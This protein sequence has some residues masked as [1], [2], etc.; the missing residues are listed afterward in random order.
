[1]AL[2]SELIVEI[3]FGRVKV[4]PA[5]KRF[6]EMDI[7]FEDGRKIAPDYVVLS[8]GYE[9]E[10]PFL[11]Q[12]ILNI[13]ENA[14]R[15]TQL[16][17]NMFHIEHPNLIFLGLPFTVH[18]FLVCELQA[19]YATS[20]LYG[21]ASL[22]SKELMVQENN[23]KISSMQ[24]NGINPVKFFH[25][26]FHLEY[27][28]RIAKY[29]GFYADPFK[30]ENSEFFMD[31]MFGPLYGVHYRISGIGKMEKTEIA[32]ILAMYKERNEW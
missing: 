8:T 2:S 16:Y 1:M 32:K 21:L 15:T 19:R 7:E 17:E 23:K 30:Y 29:G 18:P 20:V 4:L 3:G 31:L 24:S 10:F 22:P 12:E 28:D 26:E 11:D 25:R 13:D 5:V 6:S 14:C 9:L 27:C